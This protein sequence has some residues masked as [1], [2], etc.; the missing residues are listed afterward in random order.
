MSFECA[1]YDVCGVVMS[2]ISLKGLL[3][4]PYNECKWG[5]MQSSSKNDLKV[6]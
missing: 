2:R 3:Y 4:F 1:A 5:Q 6:L